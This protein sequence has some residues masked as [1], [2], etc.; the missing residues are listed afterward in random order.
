MFFAVVPGGAFFF[1]AVVAGGRVFFLLS[2]RGGAFFFCCRCGA[3]GVL[4]FAVVE[5]P[6]A[7]FL[8]LSLLMY[9]AGLKLAGGRGGG[10]GC[11]A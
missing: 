2:L 11:A 8:G 5:V 10:G 4:L 6:G 7:L 9:V 1:F 3:G